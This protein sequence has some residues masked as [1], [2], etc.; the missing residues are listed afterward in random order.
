MLKAKAAP[1]FSLD[2]VARPAQ[3]IYAVWVSDAILQTPG[4]ISFDLTMADHPMP[5]NGHMARHGHADVCMSRPRHARDR[6]GAT[7]ADVI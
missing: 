7:V 1:A 4:V 2:G 5:D 3:T 6:Q